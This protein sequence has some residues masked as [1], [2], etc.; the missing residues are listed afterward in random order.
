MTSCPR[1]ITGEVML[2]CIEA[3]TRS[4]RLRLLGEADIVQGF[5]EQPGRQL[6]SFEERL[7]AQISSLQ[8]QQIED[9]VDQRD[10]LSFSVGLKELK[11]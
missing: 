3:R 11:R 2:V 5:P 6:T 7:S 10:L 1:N 4:L 8:I 9:V